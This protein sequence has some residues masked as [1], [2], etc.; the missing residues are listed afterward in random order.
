MFSTVRVHWSTQVVN[1]WLYLYTV[2][3]YEKFSY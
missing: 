3:I 2:L 1:D